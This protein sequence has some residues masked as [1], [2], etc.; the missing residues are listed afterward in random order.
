M[1]KYDLNRKAFEKAMINKNFSPIQLAMEANMSDNTVYRAIRSGKVTLA[2]LHKIAD[3]L[4]VLPTD[5]VE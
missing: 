5:L 3:A 2:T 4:E 1:Y